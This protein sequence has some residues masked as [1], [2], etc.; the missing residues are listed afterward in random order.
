[1]LFTPFLSKE[2]VASSLFLPCLVVVLW[3]EVKSFRWVFQASCSFFFSL[4]TR[5]LM[6]FSCFIFHVYDPGSAQGINPSHAYLF[7]SL[8]QSRGKGGV[9]SHLEPML[10]L[11]EDK[12]HFCCAFV[13]DYAKIRILCYDPMNDT[14]VF[15]NFRHKNEF[16]D[17]KNPGNHIWYV[18]F[19]VV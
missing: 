17:S 18:S 13:C 7:A 19:G 11:W 3:G 8:C 9:L 16:L 14:V 5:A 10:W 4:L 15:V 12:L 2:R 6:F 1:M